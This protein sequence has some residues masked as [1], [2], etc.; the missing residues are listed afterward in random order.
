MVS[1]AGPV[2]K[3]CRNLHARAITKTT[4]RIRCRSFRTAV[5]LVPVRWINPSGIVLVHQRIQINEELYIF[6]FPENTFHGIFFKS[7]ALLEINLPVRGVLIINTFKP[8]ACI[9]REGGHSHDF[10]IRINNKRSRSVLPRAQQ[11]NNLTFQLGE[12]KIKFFHLGTC[13]EPSLVNTRREKR[14]HRRAILF[15]EIANLNIFLKAT[16]NLHLRISRVPCRR[17]YKRIR[18][19]YRKP[20]RIVLI[21][22]KPFRGIRPHAI[23]SHIDCAIL[24][25]TVVAPRIIDMQSTVLV[26]ALPRRTNLI[27]NGRRR[28]G[29]IHISGRLF[30][31]IF[32][33]DNLLFVFRNCNPRSRKL[34]KVRRTQYIFIQHFL[35]KAGIEPTALFWII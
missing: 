22:S 23:D 33:I 29:T 27:A 11:A 12:G 4:H 28:Q 9:L 14:T 32:Q 13:K 20:V 6:P 19:C 7:E 25:N 21:K 26:E 17:R 34:S 1:F 10:I 18:E 15:T 35:R 3:H 5:I 30:Q 8:A 31:R 16:S 24:I 2:Q